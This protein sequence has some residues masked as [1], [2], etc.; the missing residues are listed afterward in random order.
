[1]IP[2]IIFQTCSFKKNEIPE[3]IKIHQDTWIE[4]NPDWEYRYY[5]DTDCDNFI[6]FEYPEYFKIYNSIKLPFARADFWRYFALYH[7]GGIYADIDTVCLKPLNEWVDLQKDFI[8]SSNF[9]AELGENYEQW[10]FATTPKNIFIKAV[11]DKMLKRIQDTLDKGNTEINV[12]HTSPYMFTEALKELLPNP[13][14]LLMD[15]NFENNILHL[16]GSN[17]W[18]DSQEN[19]KLL[20]T[21]YWNRKQ[22]VDIKVITNGYGSGVIK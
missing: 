16:N 5:D 6:L 3:Y 12:Y 13:S 15:S 21:H 14:F 2:K 20:H 10:A 8:T 17:R 19:K 18:S 7:F 4:N 11:I 22:N 9:I 1:M